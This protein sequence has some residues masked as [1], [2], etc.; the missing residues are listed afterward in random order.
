MY[1]RIRMDLAFNDSD[2]RGDIIEEALR[3]LTDAVVI[4]EGD[5][6]EE[7]GYIELEDCN[8]NAPSEP[9]VITDRWEVGRGKVI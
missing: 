5:V 9:C 3:R 7:R 6:A 4:N 1:K 2:P 8:H